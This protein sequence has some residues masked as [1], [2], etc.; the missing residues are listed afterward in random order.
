MEYWCHIVQ[1]LRLQLVLL[2]CVCI[3]IFY[4]CCVSLQLIRV[5]HLY[6]YVH[7]YSNVFRIE[8]TYTQVKG[9]KNITEHLNITLITN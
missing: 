5:V 2:T 6:K 4:F 1:Q 7:Y 9:L 8:D 3:C